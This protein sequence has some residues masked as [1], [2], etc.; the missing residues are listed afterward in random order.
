MR[1]DSAGNIV[2]FAVY[3]QGSLRENPV[4]HRMIFYSC[5]DVWIFHF[6]EKVTETYCYCQVGVPLW[7]FVLCC[8]CPVLSFLCAFGRNTVLYLC[9]GCMSQRKDLRGM[10]LWYPVPCLVSTVHHCVIGWGLPMPLFP[11]H[12]VAHRISSPWQYRHAKATHYLFL[13]SSPWGK[14]SCGYTYANYSSRRRKTQYFANSCSN[15]CAEV[16]S[17]PWQLCVPCLQ[18]SPYCFFILNLVFCIGKTMEIKKTRQRN[19]IFESTPL[20]G[21]RAI[22]SLEAT[23][24][25]RETEVILRIV[26]SLLQH[27]YFVFKNYS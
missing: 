13:C 17:A 21:L 16:N 7:F 3:C 12:T 18:T 5:S 1:T 19:G 6:F 11:Q 20:T 8:F 26:G 4:R 2:F 9:R 15:N 14:A 10:L 24:T 27:I 23:T 22:R 25:I